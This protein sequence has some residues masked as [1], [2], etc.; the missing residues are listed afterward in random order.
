[1]HA[2][3]RWSNCNQP[4]I[5]AAALKEPLECKLAEEVVIGGWLRTHPSPL[6]H[7]S[8]NAKSAIKREHK[9]RI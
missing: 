8:A 9:I 3:R 1:M 5:I 4:I 6:S 7:C 2:R